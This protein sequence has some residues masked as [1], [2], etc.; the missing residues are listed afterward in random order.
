LAH[1]DGL[2]DCDGFGLILPASFLIQW[3]LGIASER[4]D[5]RKFLAY[6]DPEPAQ[7]KAR[8]DRLESPSGLM[9]S[10]RQDGA[11]GHG[12]H[13]PRELLVAGRSIQAF[14]WSV[15]REYWE[16]RAAEIRQTFLARTKETAEKW[17]TVFA[18]LLAVFGAVL[19]VNKPDLGDTDHP[20]IIGRTLILA[21]ILG[22]H[23]VA[24]TGWAAAGLPKLLVDVNAETAFEAETRQA[25]LALNRLRVGLACGGATAVVLTFGLAVAIA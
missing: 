4:K 12:V 23:A 17:R 18:G 14:T 2:S 9:F 22:L 21:L 3:R 13:E 20:K 8:R 11:K 25:C 24:Y 10:V 19:V 16:K 5:A 15:E 7:G 6:R 1:V